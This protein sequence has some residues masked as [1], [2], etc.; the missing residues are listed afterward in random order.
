MIAESGHI[1]T[2][3]EYKAQYVVDW[4]TVRGDLDITTEIRQPYVW[5]EEPD[6]F[7]KN[8][9][10]FRRGMITVKRQIIRPL[11]EGYMIVAEGSSQYID[12]IRM[13]Y[14]CG[15]GPT[16]PFTYHCNCSVL[17]EIECIVTEG[18]RWADPD[19]PEDTDI[20]WGDMETDGSLVPTTDD[21]LIE[22]DDVWSNA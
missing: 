6:G 13:N 12:Y 20:I 22:W 17:D 1:F 9:I 14:P 3:D 2:E 11:D 19:N 21:V 15:G 5:G 7:V 10:L 18:S 16:D 8:N 4:E